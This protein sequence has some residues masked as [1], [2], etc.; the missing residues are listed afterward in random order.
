M[1]YT[2]FLKEK[3]DDLTG[4]I[5]VITGANSGLGFLAAKQ[6]AYRGATIVLAVRNLDEGI[7]SLTTI[8]H[9]IPEAK[10][11]VLSLDMASFE[12]IKSF[13]AAL[14][15]TVH[16]VDAL[17]LN[18]GVY[19][20][21]QSATTIE[22]FP[23]TTGVN[24]FGAYYLLRESIGW[25]DTQG[26]KPTRLVFV[27][28][29]AAHRTNVAS[30]QSLLDVNTD[31]RL[32]YGLSKVAL[33]RL[34]HVM[35]LNL[36]LFDFPDRKNISSLLVNP[37]LSST[38]LFRNLQPTWIK[39]IVLWF[40]KTFFPEPEQAS[41]VLTYAMGNRYVVNGSYYG[42]HGLWNG[43]GQPSKMTIPNHFIQGSAKLMYDTGKLIKMKEVR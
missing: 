10:G 30:L 34:F 33:S 20:P 23:L 13:V 43:F 40:A 29:N 18:A 39:N 5:H 15:K 6:L 9:D 42:V 11:W 28:S 26:K 16:H 41:L 36:N 31:L 27:G 14:K 4:Q 17:L 7:R 1:K 21:D 12:S 24:F 8:Q 38:S 2:S 22:A 19:C 35:Q 3:I 37:G 25:L 32:Q